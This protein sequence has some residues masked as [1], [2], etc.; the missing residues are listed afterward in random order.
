MCSSLVLKVRDYQLSEN[1][2]NKYISPNY[3]KTYHRANEYNIKLNKLLVSDIDLP[4]TED[5][6]RNILFHE[7]YQLK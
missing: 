7:A 4:N 6:I 2:L 1:Y 5:N 3:T